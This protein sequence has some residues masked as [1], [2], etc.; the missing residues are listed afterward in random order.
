MHRFPPAPRPS[1]WGC[2]CGCSLYPPPPAR[3]SAPT[4]RKR[5]PPPSAAPPWPQTST[6]LCH[7]PA[8]TGTPASALGLCVWMRTLPAATRA[9]SRLLRLE[10]APP[11]LQQRRRVAV[12]NLRHAPAGNT[13]CLCHPPAPTGTSASA[14]GLRMWLQPL[15]AATRAASRS[16]ASKTRP[17][18]SSSAAVWPSATFATRQPEIPLAYATHRLP[19]APR[20]PPWGCGC[21]CSLYPPQPARPAAPTP[22]K[23]APSPPAAADVAIG[24]R[25]HAP[26]AIIRAPMPSTGS[27][28]HLGLRPGAAD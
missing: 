24:N 11:R 10:N 5:A 28:R 12:G 17:P 9:A 25:R 14:L 4:P 19:P 18:A 6:R 23:R 27:H 8:P 7:A 13:A 16:D 1:P 20:P 22:R 21:G 3:P 15:P 26:A 2:G